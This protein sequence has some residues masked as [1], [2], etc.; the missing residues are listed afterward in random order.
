[1][2]ILKLPGESLVANCGEGGFI[3]I[4]TSS[5]DGPLK[6]KQL[7]GTPAQSLWSITFLEN[8]DLAVG[9]K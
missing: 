9:A 3:E 5:I 7:I 6:H 4:W 2:T 8:G 1:M